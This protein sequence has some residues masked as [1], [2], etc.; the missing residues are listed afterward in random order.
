[1][2]SIELFETASAAAQ[3]T[4]MMADMAVGL[5]ADKAVVQFGAGYRPAALATYRTAVTSTDRLDPTTRRGGFVHFA[6]AGVGAWMVAQLLTGADTTRAIEF[7]ACSRNP[8]DEMP[9]HPPPP[10]QAMWY[11]M[12]Q[13]ERKL[14]LDTG[15]AAEAAERTRGAYI[16]SFERSRILDDMRRCIREGVVGNFVTLL[17]EYCR[18][19]EHT[20]ATASFLERDSAQQVVAKLPWSD[21]TL[22]LD[23]PVQRESA[24]QAVI[25]FAVQARLG[26]GLVVDAELRVALLGAPG[27]APLAKLLDGFDKPLTRETPHPEAIASTAALIGPESTPG[28]NGLFLASYR[29]WEWLREATFDKILAPSLGH[30]LSAQWRRV[31][32]T[33][34]FALQQPARSRPAILSACEH[35]ET[36]SDIARLLLAAEH[37]V[38]VSLSVEI[39]LVL[40]QSARET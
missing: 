13:I 21:L 22:N 9:P 18:V 4:A 1:L 33:A 24:E 3:T 38:T 23:A 39:R 30:A 16:D 40:G 11:L 36:T 26:R 6:L 31:A 27:L 37:A 10:V 14:G 7:G 20:A 29:A 28:P 8:P 2:R 34:G 17:D 32:E 35:V 19:A 25:S 12:A 15:I 5:D